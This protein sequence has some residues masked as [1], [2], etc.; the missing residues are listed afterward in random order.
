MRGYSQLFYK[1]HYYKL[2]EHLNEQKCDMIGHDEGNAEKLS[3]CTGT[4]C[5]AG[6]TSI[7]LILDVGEREVGEL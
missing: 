3:I 5:N 7:K 4:R 2:A 1:A 6:G